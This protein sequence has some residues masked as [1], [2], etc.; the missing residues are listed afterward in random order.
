MT[1]ITLTIC[2]PTKVVRMTRETDTCFSN[3]K[4]IVYTLED[5]EQ[6][7]PFGKS[8]LLKLCKKGNFP[9]IKVGKDYISNPTLIKR[10]FIENEGKEI[11]F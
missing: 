10:W 6:I 9:V 2:I 8:K 5:L 1:E 3:E 11:I 4:I 7:F